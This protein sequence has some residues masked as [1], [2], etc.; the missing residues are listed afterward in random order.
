VK[1]I[2]ID[3]TYTEITDRVKISNA[4]AA[5]ME[6]DKI[7]FRYVESNDKRLAL[8][9]EQIRNP[10]YLSFHEVIGD[11]DQSKLTR[12]IDHSICP[13]GTS[14][15]EQV[16]GYGYLVL[17]DEA[18]L[19]GADLKG[20]ADG[21]HPF[22]SYPVLNFSFKANGAKKFCEF[23]SS[24][25]NELFAVVINNEI[26]TAPNIA[27]SI[28]GGSSFIEGNFTM[29]SAKDLALR[30]NA[31]TLPTKMRVVEERVV[32]PAGTAETQK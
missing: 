30:L 17:R 32:V 13:Q 9:I 26:I 19:S 12:C 1:Q 11:I 7:R 18:I 5:K 2:A 27:G 10:I 6:S 15:Y 3:E 4:D 24:N 16:N 21:L 14:A 29:E 23:T 31:G 8:L 25:I 28:C 22:S 20:A